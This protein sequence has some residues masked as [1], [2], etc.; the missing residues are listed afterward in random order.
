M[1][2]RKYPLLH[3]FSYICIVKEQFRFW[4]QR[5]G[6]SLVCF[7]LLLL[8]TPLSLRADGGE[9]PLLVGEDLL[10][11]LLMEQIVAKA[12]RYADTISGFRSSFYMR[13]RFKVN[14]QNRL[15]RY[16]PSMFRLRKGVNDYLTET[17]GELH[18]SSPDVY[19]LKVR[20]LTGTFRRNRSELGHS[21][22][23]F[24]VN[25]YSPT[26]LPGRLVSPLDRK[27]AKYYEYRVD[28]M[29]MRGDTLQYRIAISPR[30][31]STQLVSGYMVVNAGSWT[32]DEISL[33]GEMDQLAFNMTI[34]M[35][36]E[37][38]EAFLAKRFDLHLRYKFLGNE[39]EGTY[40]TLLHYDSVMTDRNEPLSA[41]KTEAKDPYDMTDAY[42]LQ[43]D[44][45]RISADTVL[46]ARLR[47]Y[48]LT[49]AEQQLYA[50]Y[51]QSR[52]QVEQAYTVSQRRSVEFWYDVGDF[53][54]SDYTIH[55][56][57]S[58]S[59]RFSPL[60]NPV[61]FSY[62]HSNGFSY[63]QEF[64]YNHTFRNGQWMRIAPKI[65]YNFT[66]KEF[67]W[68]LYAD[69][70]YLP[71]RL[72][73]LTLKVGNGNRIYTNRVLEEMKLPGDSL[74]DFN[75][76]HLDYFY[77]E[78]LHVA[79]RIELFNGFEL[80]A[81][82]AFHRRSAVKPSELSSPEL[83]AQAGR[84]QGLQRVYNSF[85]PRLQVSWTP[86]L[87]YYMNGRRKVK[88]RSRYPTFSLDYERSI[89][90]VLGGNTE[91]ERLEV[92]VQQRI[93]LSLMSSLFYRVGAGAFTNQEDVYFVDYE[94]FTRSN[95]PVGWND[96]IGGV[97]QLLDRRWYN[98]SPRY[99][100]GH[101]TY[102]APFLLIPL[103]SRKV[104]IVDSERLYFGL[105]FTDHLAPYLEV[106]YGIGTHIF[107]LG[108]FV[109]NLNG[110]F[111]EV[112][113]KFTFELFN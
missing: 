102:E 7:V 2:S 13:G 107:D 17:S 90:G 34:G 9:E 57:N 85:S 82:I 44:T 6:S 100:R 96:D 78:Y 63:S 35:G 53:L 66:H 72:G 40:R 108:V 30:N 73:H 76:L 25:V 48:P 3:S 95:L 15:F 47:P 33:S 87:Y 41:V 11:N 39:I 94:N 105:L 110:K 8:F 49:A 5:G 16:L 62:S 36:R 59:V 65:G 79:N 24:N 56:A 18:Y 29:N 75:K 22:E 4:C 21:L 38:V 74:L 101:V 12:P 68:R 31:Q 10:G 19:N 113:C 51:A 84:V 28:A 99:L 60:I 58:G 54:V 46:M 20:N 1:Y 14:R 71:E 67:Y 52:R 89:K 104:R 61:M 83:A 112:G 91:Y 32:I 103:L 86:A 88:L 93:P 81:G 43:C 23:Y 55:L 111:G 42:L 64:R 50:E 27:G 92:D 37:G 106:G 109:N 69:Y 80:T 70:Y 26:L 98:S 77:D 45:G 97:F